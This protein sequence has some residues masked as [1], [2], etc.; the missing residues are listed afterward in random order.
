MDGGS[1]FH[2]RGGGGGKGQEGG[3]GRAAV[4][5]PNTLRSKAV[6]R[7]ID[8]ISEGECVGL[9]D[10]AKSIY[11]NN[12]PLQNADNSYNFEGVTWEQRVGTPDQTHVT[13]FPAAEA[14][15]SVGTEVKFNVPVI[16][17]ITGSTLTAIRVTIRLPSLFIQDTNNGDM[18]PT[19][20]SFAIDVQPSGGSYIT[21][22]E[23]TL[24][25][26][27]T[28]PA[29][30]SYRIELFGSSPW[31]VRVR[32][33]TADST[34]S[35]LSNQTFWSS[36]T[37]ITDHKF[38]YP[39]SA[40]VAMAVDSRLFGGNVPVR[41]Y[42]YKGRLI[43]VPNNYDPVTRAYT[44]IWDGGFKIAYSDNPAW[45]FYD[46]V[47]SHRY[48]LGQFISTGQI[49]KWSLY[50]IAQYCDELVPNGFGGTEPRFTFNGVLNSREEAFRV[51]QAIA[52][53]F[54]GMTYWATGSVTAVQD[55]PADPVLLVTNANVVN[56][57]F[58][59]S[60]TAL[61]ARHT[62]ALVTWNDPSN[63]YEPQIEVIEDHEG[64]T[65]WGV[66]EAP[67]AAFAC[68]SRGQAHRAGKWILDSEKNE[69]EMVTY[70][71]AL[72]HANARPGQIISIQ[73]R[74]YAGIAFGGR[75]SSSTTTAVTL[76][77]AV[78]LA[79]ATT[80]TLSVVL[81]DGSVE[82]R[83]VTTAAGT[84][85]TITV[86]PALTSAPVANAVWILGS[87]SVSPRKFRVMSVGEVEPH[88][89]EVNALLH[90]PTKYD[91]IEQD[92]VL[93]P[94]NYT[95]IPSG[96]LSPPETA[97]QTSFLYKTGVT[98]GSAM[99]ISWTSPKD[100]RVRSFEVQIL[101]PGQVAYEGVEVTNAVSVT[102]YGVADGTYNARVRSLDENGN[103]SAWAYVGAFVVDAVGSPPSDVTNFNIQVI[104]ER[105]NLTWDE[106]VDLDLSYY[107]IK[108]SPATSGATWGTSVDLLP[109][110][111]ATSASVPAMV[112][113]YLIK[114]Y[115]DGEK[116]S[117]NAAVIVN[118]I[119]GVLDFNAVATVNEHPSF[120]SSGSSKVHLSVPV[121]PGN[122][123]VLDVSDTIGS[124]S[125]LG[126][127]TSLGAGNYLSGTYTF[128]G[129]DLGAS[130]VSR[131]S[132]SITAAGNNL[133]NTLGSWASLGSVTSLGGGDPSLWSAT[134]EIRTTDNDPLGSPTWSAWMPFVVGDYKA[135]ATE[136]RLTI[137]TETLS[138]RPEVSALTITVDMPDRIESGTDTS[139]T[140]GDQT[141]T[142]SSA[143]KAT[144]EVGI[145]V[146]NGV[147][148]DY[149]D[150]VS[151]SASNFVY[152][153]R[154]S[155]AAR[156]ARNTDWI[157]K[158]YGVS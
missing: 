136:F 155:A 63:N 37:E 117:N 152:S 129:P 148:G 55:S 87:T 43:N 106:A 121:S 112:G 83:T 88:V 128:R 22:V 10:G 85:S 98:I 132:A 15:T 3:S 89:Y 122:T 9:V 53:V 38:T 141:I 1:I 109:K 144:P 84:T 20:V 26:K 86:S 111:S 119:S 67:I 27:C 125:T 68:T 94:I 124:W 51:I 115:D 56:G 131:I 96:P 79:A 99:V 110:I 71:A 34:S 62:V 78:T 133:D 13:G 130:Y 103:L 76:D 120:N 66:R 77:R 11:F 59:Y 138:I 93:E 91:R 100:I 81:T 97:T 4:E 127:V 41:S 92:L 35:A 48:G 135:R 70:R 151:K 107:R 12:T 149:I 7:V 36:Y 28:S 156:V 58:N 80:Y 23:Q 61:K 114:A 64:V 25:G 2:G 146:K 145:L 8:L 47:S 39:H 5:A 105:A 19:S 140:T 74:H 30:R 95:T 101:R 104:G 50:S 142:F 153:I 24:S 17:T 42:D 123:L 14:E 33:I 52:S 157:A 45:V 16:R 49:D 69:T 113:T 137:A 32:R 108:F 147:T 126:A 73:D 143:F 44:G 46:M 31:N 102:I 150:V 82:S 29:E 154:N 158:G 65:K 60:G 116:E 54:R 72:D 139:L 118:T 90:D 6:A 57:V 40:H 21:K 134:L 18:N 75:I